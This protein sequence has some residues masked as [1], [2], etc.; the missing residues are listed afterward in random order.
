MVYYGGRAYYANVELKLPQCTKILLFDLLDL[1][2]PVNVVS[3]IVGQLFISINKK[4]CFAFDAFKKEFN[5]SFLMKL[6]YY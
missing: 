3:R 2:D 5:K 1:Y 6:Q 4:I